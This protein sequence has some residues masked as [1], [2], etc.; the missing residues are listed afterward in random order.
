MTDL[1]CI[2]AGVGLGILVLRLWPSKPRP[3]WDYAFYGPCARCGKLT[4]LVAIGDRKGDGLICEQCA[5]DR[6]M[7]Q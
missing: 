4:T 1:L 6:G 3:R 2:L 7:M 5:I